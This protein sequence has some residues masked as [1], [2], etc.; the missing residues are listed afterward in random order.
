M[1]AQRSGRFPR[2]R[3]FISRLNT[4]PADRGKRTVTG[5]AK[6][7][8]RSLYASTACTER[9]YDEFGRHDLAL[10]GE[11]TVIDR[12]GT[13]HTEELKLEPGAD[14]FQL[15]EWQEYHLIARGSAMAA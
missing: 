9:L 7:Q 12:E 14:D 11:R 3:Y 15:D 8:V 4:N 2:D 10:K 6:G 1:H 13:K 5:S